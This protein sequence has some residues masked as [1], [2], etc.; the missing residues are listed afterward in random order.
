LCGACETVDDL[1]RADVRQLAEQARI[2]SLLL[3]TIRE[4]LKRR[5]G[6][7]VDANKEEHD[8]GN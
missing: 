6:G 7:A 8:D 4:E 5:Q 2:S 1:L 3:A